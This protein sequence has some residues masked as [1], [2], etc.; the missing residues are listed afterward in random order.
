MRQKTTS[1]R[2]EAKSARLE[3]KPDKLEAKPVRLEVKPG[4]METKPARVETDHLFGSKS[5]Y[6]RTQSRSVTLHRSKSIGRDLQERC[7]K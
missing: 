3:V 7:K 5:I 6:F 1:E 2:K 4:R